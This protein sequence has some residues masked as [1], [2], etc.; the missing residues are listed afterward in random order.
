MTRVDFYV[1]RSPAPADRLPVAVR[2]AEKAL[3]QGLRVF[4]NA[5][6]ETQARALDEALWAARPES[7]LP[8]GPAGS[9][10]AELIAI[11]CGQDPGDHGDLLIN[12]E[13]AVPGFFSRFQRVAEVVTQD[14][15]SLAA[16]RASWLF[17]RERG[18]ELNKHDL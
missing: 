18:Y 12:L 5:A 11:G 2:L 17:Y 6:D 1:L 15:A 9:D 10:D 14:E 3:Q 7:F 8:H 4:I 13:L 16:L